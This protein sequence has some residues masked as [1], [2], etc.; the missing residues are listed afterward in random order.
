M[1]KLA[2]V[3]FGGNA[4]L[5][6]NEAG[7]VE[8]QERN[9]TETAENLIYLLNEGYNIVITHGNGPQVGNIFMRNDAGEHVYNI[10]PMPL[11]VCVADSQGS[12]GYMI[13]RVLRNVLKK[14]G[15]NK[16]VVSLISMV[17]VDKDD[18]AFQNPIK[19]VGKIYNQEEAEKLTREK[20]WIFKS[21]PKEKG[22]YRRVVPSPVPKSILNKDI[23]E[24]LVKSGNI[25]IAGGGGGIPVY[26]DDNGNL[27]SVDAVIDKDLTSGMLATNIG[28]DELYVLTDVPYVYNNYRKP[29]QEKL[30]FLDYADAMK[31]LEMGVFAEGSMEPKIRAS[32]NFVSNGGKKSIITESKKLESSLYGSKITMQYDP[33]DLKNSE[34]KIRSD[35]L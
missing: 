20:N 17:E 35:A 29:N 9:A 21:T 25:V 18:P 27:I 7:T 26:F 2:V 3:A 8:Q 19:R 5:R 11:N 13:E 4:L 14:H 33:E 28:A 24:A 1:N 34:S 22:G 16:N 31:Y 6:N 10:T 32:L 12:I 23:I 15:I 30:E